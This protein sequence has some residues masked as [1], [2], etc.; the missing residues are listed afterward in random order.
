GSSAEAGDALGRGVPLL[1]RLIE[2]G[3]TSELRAPARAGRAVILTS[4]TTGPPKG[5]VRPRPASLDPVAALLSK[6]PLRA[7]ERTL[8]AAPMVHSWGYAH[9]VIGLALS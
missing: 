5:A 7:R 9:F 6:I 4:G 2:S 1:E 8:I 3:D